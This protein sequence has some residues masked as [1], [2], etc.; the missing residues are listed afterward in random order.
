MNKMHNYS[1]QKQRAIEQMLD[2]NKRATQN[3]KN[4]TTY[5]TQATHRES[6][7]LFMHLSLDQDIIIIL[8]LM[9]ILYNNGGD[10]MLIFSLAYILM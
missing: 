5:P 7:D 9:L 1:I 6:S 10:M 8:A 3:A 4:Q 2:M